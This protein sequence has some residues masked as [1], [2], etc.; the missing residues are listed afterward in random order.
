MVWGAKEKGVAG[1]S[2]LIRERE[3]GERNLIRERE[4]APLLRE[5]KDA[6]YRRGKDGVRGK[7]N[8]N[9]LV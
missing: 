2:N 4:N 7:Q 1:E 8:T 9:K 5:E 6:G 3:N